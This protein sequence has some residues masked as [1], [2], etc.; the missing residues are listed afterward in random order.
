MP[1]RL[2]WPCHK[3]WRKFVAS[4]TQALSRNVRQTIRAFLAHEQALI[5][6]GLE[7]ALQR[8]A[9]S[10]KKEACFTSLL[11]GNASE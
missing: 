1:A 10:L 5:H 6:Q 4:S 9:R 2:A 11:A 3:L 7:V 8:P